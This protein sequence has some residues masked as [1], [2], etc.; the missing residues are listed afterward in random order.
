MSSE[1]STIRQALRHVARESG[2]HLDFRILESRPLY[3]GVSLDGY[4]TEDLSAAAP[5]ATRAHSMTLD[6]DASA[7]LASS[8]TDSAVLRGDRIAA[9]EDVSNRT[10]SLPAV[11]N[12]RYASPIARAV[13]LVESGKIAL[14]GRPEDHIVEDNDPSEA[15]HAWESQ[16]RSP[17][18]R[19]T[20]KYVD[21]PPDHSIKTKI[22]NVFL[23]GR[24]H[25]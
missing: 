18:V 11:L 17:L 2:F 21:S 23:S 7:A 14:P 19:N 5:P 16:Y 8:N 3:E 24:R 25:T 10:G 1:S 20:L 6:M 9:S 12:A 22:R 4:L 15:R 13:V